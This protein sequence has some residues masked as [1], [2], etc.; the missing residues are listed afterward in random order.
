[1]E[2]ELYLEELMRLINELLQKKIGFSKFRKS[3]EDLKSR[4][5]K[6]QDQKGKGKYHE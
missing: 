5:R 4:I 1:M 3:Y 2:S 6:D